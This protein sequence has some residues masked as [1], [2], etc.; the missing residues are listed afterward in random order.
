VSKIRFDLDE[1]VVVH[2]RF[3]QGLLIDNR[4]EYLSEQYLFCADEGVFYLTD[5]AGGLLNARLRS[6]GIVPGQPIT[7]TKRSVPNPNSVRPII[8]YFP[9]ACVEA[10]TNPGLFAILPGDTELVIELKRSL[11]AGARRDVE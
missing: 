5:T 4:F 3:A 10:A 6:A 7:I 9:R 8:E 1:P 11:A 2:L